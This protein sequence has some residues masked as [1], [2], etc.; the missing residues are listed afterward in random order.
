MR[1][2]TILEDEREIGLSS[3]SKKSLY[4]SHEHL[5]SAMALLLE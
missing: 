4:E 3:Y 5:V 2:V 1:G